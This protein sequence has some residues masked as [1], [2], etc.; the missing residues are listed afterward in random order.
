MLNLVTYNVKDR[1][2]LEKS[3][4][5]LKNKTD[6]QFIP[7]GKEQEKVFNQMF[8]NIK[9]PSKARFLIQ[10]LFKVNEAKGSFYIAQCIVDLGYPLGNM[11]SQTFDHKYYYQAIGIVDLSI[12]FGITHLRPQTKLDKICDWFL[13]DDINFMQQEM[14]NEKYNVVSDKKQEVIKFFDGSLLKL[15]AGNNDILISTN[16][17]QLFISFCDTLKNNHLRIIQDILSIFIKK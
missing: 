3:Y 4:E 2:V 10:N 16:G 15:I 14:F 9:I 11:G 6:I 17:K 5:A 12:D 7:T 1:V 8:S 13:R